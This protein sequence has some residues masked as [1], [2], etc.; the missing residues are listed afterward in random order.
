MV[1][2]KGYIEVFVAEGR[3]ETG[4]DG[5]VEVEVDEID[6]SSRL[7]DRWDLFVE[8][9]V[10]VHPRDHRLGVV[11]VSCK[12]HHSV[13]LREGKTIRAPSGSLIRGGGGG[14]VAGNAGFGAGNAT[15]GGAG[16]VAGFG[17]G[18][19]D[20]GLLGADSLPEEVGYGLVFILPLSRLDAG[21]VDVGT[22]LLRRFRGEGIV[23]EVLPVLV[24]RKE[25]EL[26]VKIV[27]VSVRRDGRL[28]PVP[29]LVHLE[30]R[31]EVLC[32]SYHRNRNITD[33]DSPFECLLSV[34]GLKPDSYR[35]RNT[36]FI[37]QEDTGL[38]VQFHCVNIFIDSIFSL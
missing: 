30:G 13:R 21:C 32:I 3:K 20:G 9:F 19:L 35:I 5:L 31:T 37:D 6:L 24:S 4:L 7:V 27:V 12:E 16:G 18:S 15:G 1:V 2:Q 11:A 25:V 33:K 17:A 29:F 14:C 23:E 10:F 34:E 8:G 26:Q 22:Y 36:P 38:S 28:L